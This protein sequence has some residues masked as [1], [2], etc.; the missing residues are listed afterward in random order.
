MSINLMHRTLAD[1]SKPAGNIP[2]GLWN[3]I[4]GIKL[5]AKEVTKTNRDGEEFEAVEFT[6]SAEAVE[7]SSS[8]DP[9][10]LAEI[11]AATGKPSYEGKRLFLRYSD[12]FRSD[13]TTMSAAMTAF[14]IPS[15]T[16]L[17]AIVD[18]NLV[19]GKVASG[20]IF[21]RDFK[22]NDGSDGVEQK[23]RSWA[24]VGT[25]HGFAL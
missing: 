3:K 21:N 19:K 22:R 8:V 15:D 14:G 5:T 2:T 1:L 6:L 7:P 9:D 20:E 18:G 17:Q 4:R 23:V 16:S 25:A 11:D 13:M 24:K 10:A 12:A